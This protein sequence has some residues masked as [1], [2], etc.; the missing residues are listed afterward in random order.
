MS[1][2]HTGKP[3]SGRALAGLSLAAL[4]VVY[5]DIGTSPLYA[6]KECFGEKHGIPPTPANVLGVLSLIVWS[7]NFV[8]SYK[9]IAQVMRADNR[10]EGGI[11]A[12][13]ALVKKPTDH[14]RRTVL[15]TLGLFGA[16]LLYGDGVITPAISVL[17]AIEGIEYATPA[18]TRFVVPI[19]TVILFVLFLFQKK[20]TRGVGRVFGPVMVVWFTC[21]ALLGLGGIAREPGVL[22][23][24]N[25]WYAIDFFVRDGL[26]GFLILGAVVLV[27]TGGE[28][29]YADMGH[30][31]KRPIRVAWFG[32]V[33]PALMLNYFGQAA[34]LLQ[35]PTAAANPFYA[36]VPVKLQY[37]M[38]VVATAAAI[39]ASQALISG[40]F[41][42]TQ[43]A[44][45]L[46]YS[47]R[48]TIRH[49]S[50][51]ER[52]Q[53]YVPEVNWALMVACIWLVVGFRSSSNLAAA[54]GI[55]VTGTMA[56]TTILFA[57]VAQELWHWTPLKAWSLCGLFL[58]VDLSFFAA[59]IIKFFAGGWF[60]VVVAV[61][62]FVLMS[63]WKRGRA[64]L[65]RIMEDISLPIDLFI[66]DIGK[67]LP[68]R[69]PGTAV[70][71]TS[72]AGG[73][74]PVLLHHVKHNKVLH[75]QV[76]LMSVKTD[77][78]PYVP[79]E[80]RVEFTDL[81]QK[82]YAVVAHHGFME[83]ADV[84]E[85]LRMLQANGLSVR[86]LETTFYL[87]RET[88]IAAPDKKPVTADSP[89]AMSQWRKKLF[90]LM[91]RNAQTATA[92]FNLPPNRVVEMGA[93]I[94]F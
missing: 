14:R 36:L 76:I 50:E 66:S 86:P 27:L 31:G 48:M 75:E 35:D 23:A 58:F 80:E 91:S 22:K 62:V 51:R 47:P 67:R 84:P 78:V 85:V 39:V 56:I 90:I 10:G 4:G 20:G 34:L 12:L 44:I 40:A 3:L 28:A 6:L 69:V 2:S 59:N 46:G 73:A 19:T 64:R 52:G 8:V 13:L 25:P 42:L 26:Q 77:E 72:H 37:P 82:F 60:P 55:A 1:T 33:L 29:L 74:P 18:L 21:I 92:F 79:D 5:G 43:Q 9:Y 24:L 87:G 94:Q 45:Q 83:G 63:T 54:Y 68:T 70:F 11:L 71:M 16:A 93:Q 65:T 38:V 17:G 15:V 81:G 32:M 57:V 49:T 41:S 88:L 89:P 53:I 7:M 61:G 30:F